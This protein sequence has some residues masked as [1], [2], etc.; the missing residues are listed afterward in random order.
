MAIY[1][2]IAIATYWLR[3]PSRPKG[4]DCVSRIGAG[5]RNRPNP[6]RFDV[7]A[8]ASASVRIGAADGPVDAPVGCRGKY[9]Q[10]S[11]PR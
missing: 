1:R 5:P 4:A 3:G 8:T 6:F 7:F 10:R 11:R 9:V 2:A